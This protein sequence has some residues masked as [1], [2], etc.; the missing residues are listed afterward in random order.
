MEVV[1]VEVVV[2]ILIVLFYL[3]VVIQDRS[4][5]AY[6]SQRTEVICPV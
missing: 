1:V 6:G 2:V 3:A 5:I 4:E